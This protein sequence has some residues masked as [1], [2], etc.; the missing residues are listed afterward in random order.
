MLGGHC[1][2]GSDS[3]VERS[4]L[5]DRVIVGADCSIREAV[6]ARG[7]RVGDGARVEPGAI[8]GSGAR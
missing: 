3:A 1:S 5:H 6:L 2:V 7:V 8:V 4:V